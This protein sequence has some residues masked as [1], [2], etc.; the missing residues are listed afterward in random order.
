MTGEGGAHPWHESKSHGRSEPSR[1]SLALKSRR[2]GDGV[3]ANARLTASAG[4]VL[5]VLLAVEG[6]TILRV[7][8]LLGAH[9]FVGMMLIPPVALKI[10]STGYRFVR[11]YLGSSAYRRKGA[12]PVILRLIGPAM[13]VLTVVVLASGVALVVAPTASRSFLLGLHKASFVAWFVVTAVHVLGHLGDTARDASKDWTRRS[14]RVL[15]GT[16]MRR[17]ALVT[18]L[19]VGVG[20]GAL[21]VG[22]AG[23]YLA[24]TSHAVGH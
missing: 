15:A 5:F 2:S 17:A 12:P 10:G 13:V 14:A 6:V 18:T 20:L 23:P 3:E 9:I 4:A 16:P 22:R 19:A 7:R 1:R 11:Y 24:S 21:L 8:G